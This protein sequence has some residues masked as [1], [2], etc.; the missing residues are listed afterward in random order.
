MHNFPILNLSLLI[1]FLDDTLQNEKS[2]SIDPFPNVL[3]L[4]SVHLTRE[5]AKRE[6]TQNK[7]AKLG[8]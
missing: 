4:T 3:R 5:R 7:Q 2:T 8:D 1:P 6:T